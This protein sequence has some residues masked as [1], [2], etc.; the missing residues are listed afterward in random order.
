MAYESKV[1]GRCADAVGATHRCFSTRGRCFPAKERFMSLVKDTEAAC[2][3]DW[4]RIIEYGH[5]QPGL[6]PVLCLGDHCESL[7]GRHMDPGLTSRSAR[8][9]DFLRSLVGWPSAIEAATQCGYLSW[10][11]KKQEQIID[12]LLVSKELLGSS[13][14]P[15][16]ST[17]QIVEHSEADLALSFD[18]VA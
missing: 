13:L 17:D 3:P 9:K 5:S 15:G 2:V 12:R 6:K 4:G 16:I 8:E 1:A 14:G 18:R 10:S 7:D 11:T